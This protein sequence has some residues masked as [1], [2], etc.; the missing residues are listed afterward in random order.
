MARHANR[1]IRHAATRATRWIAVDAAEPILSQQLN[2]SDTYVRLEAVYAIRY[3]FGDTLRDLLEDRRP[4]E[5]S[6][7]VRSALDEAL[8]ELDGG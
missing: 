7:L 6:P 4:R 5:H 2:D 3:S 8:E 1:N